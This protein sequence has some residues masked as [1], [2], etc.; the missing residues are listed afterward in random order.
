MHKRVPKSVTEPDRTWMALAAYNVG[1]G[2]LEDARVITQ[3]QGGEPKPMGRCKTTPTV[4]RQAQI[5]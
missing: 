3:Q 2:H 5:L 1:L 4:T